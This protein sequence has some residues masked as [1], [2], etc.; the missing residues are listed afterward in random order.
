MKLGGIGAQRDGGVHVDRREALREDFGI[1]ALHSMAQKQ[2]IRSCRTARG[3]YSFAVWVIR[4]QFVLG[5]N[6]LPGWK[7]LPASRGSPKGKLCAS[8]W[9]RPKRPKAAVRSCDWL[10]RLAALGLCRGARVFRRHERH[11]RHG[12]SRC[13]CQSRGRAPRAFSPVQRHYC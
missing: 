8:S 5:R 1:E 2:R 6:W 3:E 10:A 7:K 11:R 13:I 4:L 9:K 12:L